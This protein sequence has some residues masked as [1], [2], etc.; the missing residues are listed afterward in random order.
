MSYFRSPRFGLLPGAPRGANPVAPP[1][2]NPNTQPPNDSQMCTSSQLKDG[3]PQLLARFIYPSARPCGVYI[4]APLNAFPN[5]EVPLI[6]DDGLGTKELWILA[7]VTVGNGGCTYTYETD[8]PAGQTVQIQHVASYLEVSVR[9]I[10]RPVAVQIGGVG[11]FLFRNDFLFPPV[12]PLKSKFPVYVNS[13]G[14]EGF[15]GLSNCTR[16]ARFPA[17][18]AAAVG[19]CQPPPFASQAQ[20]IVK[21]D[22]TYLWHITTPAGG[23]AIG[24]MPYTVAEIPVPDGA[25]TSLELTPAGGAVSA[26][27]VWRLGFSGVQA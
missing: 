8:I 27:I 4:N 7:R 26:E 15:L 25:V 16:R 5:S 21:S 1:L 20:L 18:T 3:T 22:T 6:V 24:P 17:I 19:Q 14:G 9:L 13:H 2:Q 23:I 11:P 12:T 10:E